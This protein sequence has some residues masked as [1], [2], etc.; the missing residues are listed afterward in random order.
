MQNGKELTYKKLFLK[1]K[2]C[3]TGYTCICYL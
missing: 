1:N 2:W 3:D